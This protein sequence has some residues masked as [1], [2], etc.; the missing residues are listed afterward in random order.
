MLT[1]P[2]STVSLETRPPLPIDKQAT[3]DDCEPP[4]LKID[5]MVWYCDE[6]WVSAH[7]NWGDLVRDAPAYFRRS[8]EDDDFELEFRDF[9]GGDVVALGPH[10]NE[11][12]ISLLV[13]ASYTNEIG[14]LRIECLSDLD[15]NPSW[16]HPTVA[17]CGGLA[18]EARSI[19]FERFEAGEIE[20][21]AQLL[22]F[23]SLPLT[24][25]E[26]TRDTATLEMWSSFRQLLRLCW[27]TR[28][29]RRP[30]R[31]RNPQ[32][33]SSLPVE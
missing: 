7:W 28:P 19:V 3:L 15:E 25:S 17:I 10:K 2:S 33:T 12:S 23:D 1:K 8:L 16:S 30:S 32:R 26:C 4:E 18:K 6:A 11:A 22:D 27:E 20:P 29:P 5:E 31:L 9:A 13:V 24:L 14:G 21:E